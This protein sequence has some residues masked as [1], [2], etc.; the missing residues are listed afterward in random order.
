[1]KHVCGQPV[2]KK[3]NEYHPSPYWCCPVHGECH[4]DEISE[5]A[6]ADSQDEGEMVAGK[7]EL[8]GVE[9]ILKAT[10]LCSNCTMERI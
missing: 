6:Q 1:M 2:T 4:P 7:C 9:P 8:C 5:D 10:G 3:T